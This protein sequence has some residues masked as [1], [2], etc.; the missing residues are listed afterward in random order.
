MMNRRAF[1]AASMAGYLVVL[2]SDRRRRHRPRFLQRRAS[3]IG[4]GR[5]RFSIRI[6][7]SSRSIIASADTLSATPSSAGITLG[8]CGRKG[9]PGM[10][11]GVTW[12]GVT[13][14]TMSRCDGSKTTDVSRCFEIHPV[15]AMGTHSIS[16][17]V[18][19]PASMAAG[20]WCA[21]SRTDR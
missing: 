9:P 12:C 15:T 7:I 1:V 17:A 3:A 11:W 4:R 8:H 19:C 18:N 6:P 14:R 20:A 2:L 5:I 10:G 21:T 16:K 13:Y